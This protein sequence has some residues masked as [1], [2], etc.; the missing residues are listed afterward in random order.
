MSS[1][2]PASFLTGRPA[3]DALCV[4]QDGRRAV[5]TCLRC[6]AF[7]C[8]D[9]RHDEATGVCLFCFERLLEE[10]ATALSR[11]ARRSTIL[12]SLAFPPLAAVA[13]LVVVL[14]TRGWSALSSAR[15]G[16]VAV[17]LIFGA[18]SAGVIVS[19]YLA[20]EADSPGQTAAGKLRELFRLATSKSTPAAQRA[21]A[22]SLLARARRELRERPTDDPAE[23][24]RFLH[25]LLRAEG[26]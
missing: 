16:A 6:G 19:E 21:Q 26:A 2:R 10:L 20:S 1:D 17:L 5:T 9:C 25:E 13:L 22:V 3:D 18:L 14:A 24:L 11:R 15:A 7:L 12:Q 4:N 8:S 23:R